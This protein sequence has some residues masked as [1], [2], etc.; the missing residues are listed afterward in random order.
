[1]GGSRFG[2]LTRAFVFL[3]SRR[4]LGRLLVGL[5]V[6]GARSWRGP[7]APSAS[8]RGMG[9][10]PTGARRCTWSV[11]DSGKYRCPLTCARGGL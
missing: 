1:M 2:S 11:T 8:K 3:R 6:R 7:A 9:S 5:P 4:G 10:I